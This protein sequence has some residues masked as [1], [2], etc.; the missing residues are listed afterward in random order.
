MSSDWFH[1][2]TGTTPESQQAW[3]DNFNGGWAAGDWTGNHNRSIA[4]ERYDAGEWNQSVAHYGG[5]T[6]PNAVPD[7]Y[8]RTYSAD[9]NTVYIT[10]PNAGGGSLATT[11]VGTPGGNGG[12]TAVAPSQPGGTVP[13]PGQT[14][15]KGPGW[16]EQGGGYYTIQTMGGKNK[17]PTVQSKDVQELMVGGGGLASNPWF[18]NAEDWEIRYAEPG[19]WVGGLAVMAADAIYNTG[20]LVDWYTGSDTVS[21]SRKDTSA[22]TDARRS[23]GAWSGIHDAFGRQFNM[24]DRQLH[25]MLNPDKP[26]VG[27]GF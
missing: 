16:Y 23:N 25:D 10:R 18:S 11:G 5:Y 9:G 24:W 21:G 13:G 14:N 22:V 3:R 17:L 26:Y 6:Q 7:G 19:E 8:T 27:G 4:S 1:S 15:K 20:R 2:V 12:P